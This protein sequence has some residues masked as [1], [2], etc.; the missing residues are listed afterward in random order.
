MTIDLEDYDPTLVKSKVKVMENDN[1]YIVSLEGQKIGFYED[2][3]DN[4]LLMCSISKGKIVLDVCC[5]SG[6]LHLMLLLEVLLMLLLLTLHY[7]LWKLTEENAKLNDI[8]YS[9]I[10]FLN[11]Y[12]TKFMKATISKEKSWDLDIL[13]PPK[14]APSRKVLQHAN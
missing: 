11:E 9:K 5:Y 10:Y 12:S 14:L 7:F 8:S 6:A 1:N 2:Q 4:R 3:R 13:D